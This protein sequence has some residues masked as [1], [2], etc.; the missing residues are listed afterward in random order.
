M[1]ITTTT[2]FFAFFSLAMMFHVALR[3][4]QER[5]GIRSAILWFFLWFFIGFFSLFPVLLN[6][7]ADIAQMESRILFVLLAA[8]FILFAFMFSVTN[9]MD[10]MQRRIER[11]VQELALTNF[12]L[13]SVSKTTNRKRQ[14]Q[15]PDKGNQEN[16]NKDEQGTI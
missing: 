6:W 7:A 16:K 3:V 5:T 13:E 10:R 12:R 1:K 2:L 15:R 4:K 11:L 14:P 9:R 8:V